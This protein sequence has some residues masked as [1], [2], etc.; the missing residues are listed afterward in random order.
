[1]VR[2]ATDLNG[3]AKVLVWSV[4]IL[5]G[6]DLDPDLSEDRDPGRSGSILT[7]EASTGAELRA[8]LTDS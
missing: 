7:L 2:N 6:Q 5:T 1:M 8:I 4:K 3:F